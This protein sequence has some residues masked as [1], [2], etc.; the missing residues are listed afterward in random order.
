MLRRMNLA[1]WNA[2]GR[3]VR[4]DGHRIFVREDGAG[5]ALLFIHGFP[6]SSHD[7]EPVIARLSLSFRCVSFDL[8]GFGASDKPLIDYRFADQ[9]RVVNAVIEH[10]SLSS[11]VVVAHDY[12]ASVAQLLLSRGL[13]RGAPARL[14]GTV[15]LNGGIEPSLHRPRLVQTLL[16]TRLG[17]VLGPLFSGPKLFERSMRAI[18]TR[19][20]KLPLDEM[21]RGIEL[22]DG[23]RVLPR[24]LAYM[25]ERKLLR[26]ELMGALENAASPLGFAWGMADPISGA[27]VLAWV[28]ERIANA[29][30]E[31]LDGIGHYPQLEATPQV[32][33]F[34]ERCASRWLATS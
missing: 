17:N 34:I 9:L 16:A 33:A 30:I 19:P 22:S 12:G 32:G 28:R 31:A 24:L 14:S 29:E 18:V 10:A 6:T 27:H 8:L 21:W 5:P 2:G 4:V 20:E 11:F 7:W 26:A 25:N 3:Y 15:L 1:D 23:A 13:S